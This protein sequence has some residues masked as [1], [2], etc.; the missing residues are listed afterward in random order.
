MPLLTYFVCARL[1]V[2]A[3]VCV[4]GC[5]CVRACMHACLCG[6]VC[7][8]VCVRA[9]AC[10]YEWLCVG[11]GACACECACIRA[12][13]H[14]YILYPE[15]TPIRY[16]QKWTFYLEEVKHG[17]GSVLNEDFSLGQG[18]Y[19][20]LLWIFRFVSIHDIELLNILRIDQTQR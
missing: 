3:P 6:R 18:I 15:F 20:N 17:D 16:R 11:L 4:R 10:V 1:C 7:M 13:L 2:C 5:V 19:F 8:S 14:A 12:T 9:Y